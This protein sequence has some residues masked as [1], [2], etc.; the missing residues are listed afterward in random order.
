M[1]PESFTEFFKSL[2]ELGRETVIR[3][4]LSMVD[5]SEPDLYTVHS[6]VQQIQSLHCPNCQ[7]IDIRANGKANVELILVASGAFFSYLQ[8]YLNLMT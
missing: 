2:D 8:K 7:D 4:L 3:E 1:V 6:E 5:P